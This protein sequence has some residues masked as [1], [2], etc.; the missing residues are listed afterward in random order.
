MK[1]QFIGKVVSFRFQYVDCEEIFRGYVIDYNDD[2][3]LLKH[4][5]FDYFMDGY[6]ILKNAHII[7][8]KRDHAER[9]AEKILTAKGAKPTAAEKIPI[10]NLTAMLT[11]LT[12]SKRVFQFSMRTSTTCWI[13]K[14]KKIKGADLKIRYLSPSAKWSDDM[15]EFKLGN[16]R[17]LQ[18]DNDYIN[19]LLLIAK[20]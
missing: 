8:W 10:K 9:F 14:V 2:W 6:V 16:I 4:N 19:S 3:T 18:F 15:P 5:R 13:G 1:K 11:H 7:S 12:D 20:K 17:S